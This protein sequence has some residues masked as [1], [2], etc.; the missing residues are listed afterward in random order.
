MD[1]SIDVKAKLQAAG[2][3]WDAKDTSSQFSGALTCDGKHIE[4]VSSAELVTPNA[5]L[6]TEWLNGVLKSASD[7]V[8]G[9]TTQGDCTLLGLQEISNPSHAD[10]PCGSCSWS[11]SDSKRKTSSRLCTTNRGYGDRYDRSFREWNE[12]EKELN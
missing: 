5:Q 10:L 1:K 3:F 9:F 8:H 6:L 12:T 2:V 4:L 11:I 7:V